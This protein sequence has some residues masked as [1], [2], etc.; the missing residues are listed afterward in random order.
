MSAI[1]KKYKLTK[2]ETEMLLFLQD[3]LTN[4]RIA[5]ELVLSESTVKNHV[6][7]LMKKLPISNRKEIPKW[8]EEINDQ[9]SDD[10][11]F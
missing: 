3:E 6:S 2:R 11:F 4:A 8:I 9:L 5:A 1:S 10:T 7:N